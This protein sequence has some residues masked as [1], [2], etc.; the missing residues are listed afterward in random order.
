M[1]ELKIK[2]ELLSLEE[3]LEI[4]EEAI[5]KVTSVCLSDT[6]CLCNAIWLAIVEKKGV[7][8]GHNYSTSCIPLFSRTNAIKYGNAHCNHD[9]SFWWSFSPCDTDARLLFLNWMITQIKGEIKR[10]K[11]KK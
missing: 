1:E 3:Q 8:F 9:V 4:L 5:K 2:S 10:E 6:M 11:L 7:V